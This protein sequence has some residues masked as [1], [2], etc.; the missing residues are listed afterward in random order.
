MSHWC[1]KCHALH[2]QGTAECPQQVY[3]PT[4]SDP[5]TF[6]ALEKRWRDQAT[7]F[8]LAGPVENKQTFE[9]LRFCAEELAALAPHYVSK[10]KVRE[11]VKRINN[12]EL[13]ANEVGEVLTALL[14]DGAAMKETKP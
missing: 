14:G 13:Y 5:N 7:R 12:D 10:S 11:L 2:S 8:A 4:M 9:A 1:N 3:M 6:E